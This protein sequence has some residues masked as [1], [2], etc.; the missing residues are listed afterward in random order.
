LL[1]YG[2]L[3]FKHVLGIIIARRLGGVLVSIREADGAIER[4]IY[5]LPGILI[6]TIVLIAS[7]G[8]L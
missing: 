1:I 7:I 8:G 6:I 5:G 4:D 3:V 2:V